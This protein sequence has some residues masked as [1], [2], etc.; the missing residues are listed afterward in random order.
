MH[1]LTYLCIGVVL[2]IGCLLIS[3]QARAA[4]AETMTLV[5]P[6]LTT[7]ILIPAEPT[8]PDAY[9]AEELATYLEKI[10]GQRV[11]VVQ[12]N[13]MIKGSA[14]Q[15]VIVLGLHPANADFEA[16]AMDHD[17][18]VMDAQPG[19]LRIAGGH[20]EIVDTPEGRRPINYR[21]TLNGV[22]TFLDQQGVR[23][24][25]P[26]PW[27]EH[28]P[29][30]SNIT[31]KL[32]REQHAP[33]YRYR[34]GATLY[35]WYADQTQEEWDAA[36]IWDRR[37][38]T[39]RAVGKI[40][41]PARL[42]GGIAV[43]THHNIRYLMPKSLHD[44]HPEYFALVDGE[45]IKPGRHFHIC[46]SNPEV[47]RI[48]TENALKELRKRSDPYAMVSLEPD[49]GPGFCECEPCRALDDPNLRSRNGGEKRL[50]MASMSN[51]VIYFT[52]KVM[53]GINKERP[54]AKAG[55]YAY[56]SHTETPTLVKPHPNLIVAPTTMGAA[57]SDL[58]K[59]L[60]DPDSSGNRNFKEV[61]EG[62]GSMTSALVTR[63]YLSGGCWYGP[64]PI[65]H[66][67]QD[68]FKRYRDFRVEGIV[69]EV[70]PSWG[71]QSVMHYFLLRLQWNPDL[72]LEAEL[73]RYCD[74]MYG[75]GSQAMYNYFMTLE[76]LSLE[77]PDY[78]YSARFIDK[79]FVQPGILEKFAPH[80][81]VARRLIGDQEPYATRLKGD[82]A[83]FEVARVRY[84]VERLK[85]Q[86]K[87]DEAKALWEQLR[88]FVLSPEQNHHFD[89]GPTFYN[90]TWR[91]MSE[92]AQMPYVAIPKNP[93][94]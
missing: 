89:A 77:G 19:V 1:R 74:D 24:Y 50:G 53:E 5:G 81:M 44:T 80:I 87:L 13:E 59:F 41:N 61:L 16:H 6:G 79:L 7:R 33:V 94:K 73:R 11:E 56:F 65:L 17:S 52:N 70:H 43:P 29:K 28:V 34:M 21:G 54:H 55:L 27:G 15:P 90:Y 48:V 49:D 86:K 69:N 45:R 10:T 42:G 4:D 84:E 31:V 88:Q 67:L 85:E 3:G 78:Y 92:Q 38:R 8:P 46:M 23:W 36:I 32:G 60:D 14:Q 22:Y 2:A 72:D 26:T 25:N 75:P 64:V 63:E 62:W 9:A 83:G 40:K 58:S 68:R 35:R 93:P 20:S 37:N 18:F 91:V 12:S 39:N 82:L 71:P 76:K 51:R 30:Q 47:Q 57:Y 66:V